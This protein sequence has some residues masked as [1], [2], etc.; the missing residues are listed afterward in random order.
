MLGLE[1]IF[2][3]IFSIPRFSVLCGPVIAAPAAICAAPLRCEPH[4]VTATGFSGFP[5]SYSPLTTGHP[6]AGLTL[7]TS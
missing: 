4:V 5:A 2:A 6:A 7:F 3:T 1:M